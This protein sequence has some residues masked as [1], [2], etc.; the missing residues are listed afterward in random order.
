[1]RKSKGKKLLWRLAPRW[2]DNIKIIPK[3]VGWKGLHW[4]HLSKEGFG[5]NLGVPQNARNFLIE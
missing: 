5:L 4:A 3:E 2:E 1:V